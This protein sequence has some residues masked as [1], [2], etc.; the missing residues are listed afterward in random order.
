MSHRI[1]VIAGDG[2]GPEVVAEARKAVDALGLD[3][4]WHELP[5]GTDHYHEHG[6]MM[7]ADAL[8]VVARL[9]RGAARRGRRSV[10]ARP[11]H[12]LGP[13]AA[14]AAGTRPLGE[15][16]PRAPARRDPVE[17]RGPAERRHALRAREHGGRVLGRRRP[18]APGARARGRD[19]D[20]RLHARRRPPRRRVRVRAR[21][22]AARRRS[23]ARPSRTRRA[24]ATC[25][26]TRSP[27]RSQRSIR[28]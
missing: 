5:W 12:A 9:R 16:P 15:P 23:R 28:T 22:E 27:R 25:S 26:G 18:R 3:L 24:T 11:R 2:A 8:D 17:A 1:A 13:A 4:T 21:R 7:P 19:R 20:E 6:A 14:A 10:G